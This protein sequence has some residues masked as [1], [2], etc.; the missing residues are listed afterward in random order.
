MSRIP[1]SQQY[2]GDFVESLLHSSIWSGPDMQRVD[3]A[4]VAA[5]PRKINRGFDL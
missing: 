2:R 3:H 4:T 1:S 5:F